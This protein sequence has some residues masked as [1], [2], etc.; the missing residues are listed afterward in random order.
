MTASGRNGFE[1][2]LLVLIA[3]WSIVSWLG[4]TE[5]E[6]IAA[7]FTPIGRPIWFAVLIAGSVLALLG[8]TLGTYTG[9]MI[10]RGALFILAGAFGWVGLAFL[11]FMTRVDAL[12]LGYVTPMLLA[13]AF[14]AISRAHQIRRDL[15]RM[16]VNMSALAA[17]AVS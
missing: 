17:P 5:G 14:V 16:R 1:A 13:A 4:G 9:L 10:E 11:G 2:Y 3:G 15:A 7:V 12:H 6:T 8:V